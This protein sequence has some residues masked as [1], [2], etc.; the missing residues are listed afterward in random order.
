M[1][2]V[3]LRPFDPASDESRLRRWL[4]QTHVTRWWGAAE[5]RLPDVLQHP[6]EHHAV[7][8]VDGT[9]VGY[10]CWQRVPPDELEAAGLPDL[11]QG[12]VDVDV[13][14]GESEMRGQGIGTAVGRLLLARWCADPDVSFAG[15]G[16]SASNTRSLRAAEKLGLQLFRE[17]Q[18]PETGPSRYLLLATPGA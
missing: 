14:I 10:V 6:A 11:P 16:I 15:V 1:Q 13:F 12:T 8:V 7:I 4:R 3:A 2:E 17:Y 5:E 18:D 9:P